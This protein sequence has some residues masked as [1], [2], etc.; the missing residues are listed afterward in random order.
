MKPRE[1][2]LCAL[3]LEEPD[4]VPTF[5]IWFDYP[6]EIVGESFRTS[7]DPNEG[8]VITLYNASILAE[9]C[10]KIGYDGI[11]PGPG[12]IHFPNLIEAIK[13]LKKVAPEYLIIGSAGGNLGI[14]LGGKM[15]S[16]TIRKIYTDPVGL[17]GENL[18]RV[19]KT[20][21]SIKE[22]ADAGA[23]AV[24]NC[25]DLCLKEG[26]F[27]K[28]ELYEEIIFPF[29]KMQVDAAHGKG[30]YY[31]YHTDGD[32]W[33]IL[34][35]LVA[36]GID[37]LHSIDPTGG[38]KLRDVK[39]IYGSKIAL[40]GNVDAANT[41]VHGTPSQVEK[42]AKDC[43]RD[44]AEGGGYFLTTSNC[45]YKGIPPINALTLAKACK[46]YGRYKPL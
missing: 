16:E 13:I 24:I 19:K 17:E 12:G 35:G 11:R 45:I 18:E 3:N 21:E 25:A 41:M 42:E 29:V 33:P 8:D 6:E 36:T 30:L 20:I 22:Q 40:C 31:I 15:M 23:D 43:I 4:T 2:A 44:A 39:N 9:T 28:P 1:R 26:P 7:D 34:R 10:K 32:L 38:M 14:P 5:E 27:I 46:K 37:A